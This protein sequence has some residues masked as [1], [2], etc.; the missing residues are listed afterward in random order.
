M[1]KTVALTL[2]IVM[3]IVLM[4][5]CTTEPAKESAETQ[6]STEVSSTTTSSETTE[7]P[8]AVEYKFAV[9]GPGVHPFYTLFPDSLADVAADYGLP[10]IDLEFPQEF[11][12]NEQNTILDGLV[13]KGYN[14]IAIQPSD[15]VAANEKIS[16]LAAQGIYLTGFGAAP[17]QPTD[18]PFCVAT[19]CYTSAKYAAETLVNLIGGEGT[20][21]HLTGGLADANTEIRIKAVEDVLAN[22]P[23]VKLL[24]TITD[25]DVAEPAQNAINNLMGA[26]RDDIDGILCTAYVPTVTLAS[27]F[28]QMNETRIKVVG[29]DTDESVLQAIRDGFITGTMA[30]N[31][32]AM[33]YI[34]VYGLKLQADGKVYKADAPF[35]VDSGTFFVDKSNVDNVNEELAKVTKDLLESFTTYFE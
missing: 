7:A 24:Q 33:A 6:Q 2:A 13:A 19:D 9:V 11:N 15:S 5:G 35:N 12:Q 28:R 31:P 17:V 4:A 21:V 22:Y 8:A 30:Q 14:G 1:K 32:Y 16:E 26:S 20:I 10:E 34:S 18:V 29:I 3:V 27:V 23:N 25:I